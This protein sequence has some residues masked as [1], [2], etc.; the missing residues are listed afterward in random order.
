M[1]QPKW[2]PIE[3]ERQRRLL[4]LYSWGKK[5]ILD[6]EV[7]ETI[8]LHRLTNKAES[9][10]GVTYPTALGYARQ[11]LIRLRKEAIPA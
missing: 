10:Y 3:L 6:I 5:N 11:V 2:R 7:F 9:D 1:S 4:D 8:A